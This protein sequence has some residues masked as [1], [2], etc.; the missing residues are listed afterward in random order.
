MRSKKSIVADLAK[1][2]A[3]KALRRDANQTTCYAIYQPKLPAG[4]ERFK[5]DKA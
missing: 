5:K 4:M 1:A 3:E 2:V